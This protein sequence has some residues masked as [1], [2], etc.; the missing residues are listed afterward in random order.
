MPPNLASHQGYVAFGL[1]RL[2][3]EAMRSPHVSTARERLVSLAPTSLSRWLGGEANETMRADKEVRR[4][5][6]TAVMSL[7]A[8]T[9]VGNSRDQL[10]T[11]SGKG[12]PGMGLD[13]ELQKLSKKGSGSSAFVTVVRPELATASTRGLPP[14]ESTRAPLPAT[15]V[16]LRNCPP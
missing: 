8:A 1:D 10:T 3:D 5:L 16:N 9:H 4:S 12:V 14:L 13:E 6:R 2:V 15:C 7:P 11:A